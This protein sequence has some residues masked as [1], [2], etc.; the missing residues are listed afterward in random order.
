MFAKTEKEWKEIGAAYTAEEIF[1]QP[2]TW[3]KTF[4]QVRKVKEE[5]DAF[6]GVITGQDDF[7]LILTGAGSSEYTGN[8]LAGNLQKEYRHHVKSY[9]STDITADPECYLSK[10]KPTLLVSFARSGNSPESLAVLQL[11]EQL[12]SEVRHLLITCHGEGAMAGFGKERENCFTLVLSPE[13]N[14]RAFAMTSSFTNMYLA[15]YLALHKGNMEQTARELEDV[16]ESASEFLEHGWETADRLVSGYDFDRIVYLGSTG[17]KGIA[18][19]SALKMCELTQGKVDTQYQSPMGFRH[20]PKSVIRDSALTVIYLSGDP[21]TR[22][23]EDDLINEM[24]RERKGNRILA[25]SCRKDEVTAAVDETIVFTLKNELPDVM[26]ALLYILAGQLTALLK[27]LKCGIMPDD[28]CP[29]GEVNRVVKGVVI[30]PY[31]ERS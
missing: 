4:F 25:V 8:S 19:E 23:Y 14:D 3:G 31:G 28:P 5:L 10:E 21:Y 13:T 6:T 24:V 12:C 20:G 30:H 29:S 16:I 1:Q 22:Q 2:E 26:N 11:A 18:Q 9:A 17:L 15:A 7:D 27:S